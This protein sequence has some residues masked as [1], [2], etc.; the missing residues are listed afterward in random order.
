MSK[1][2]EG[3]W[4]YI[5]IFGLYQTAWAFIW[6]AYDNFFPVF[7]QAGGEH[8]NLLN[9]STAVGF[10]LGAFMTG[11]IMSLD[12]F[13]GLVFTPMFGA[14]SDF[15]KSRK[16]ITIISGLLAA[17]LVMVLP[18]FLNPINEANSGNL[19]LLI[20]P[21]LGFILT[22]F[23]MILFWSV[24]Q[25]AEAGLK[26]TLI[27]P[28]AYNRLTSF[29]MF[30]GGIGFIAA[31]FLNSM[32][33]SISSSLPFIAAGTVLLI[34]MLLYT[35][36]LKEPE[37]MSMRGP[38]DEFQK[39][40]HNPFKAFM[41]AFKLLP[42]ADIRNIVLLYLVKV[43]AIFGIMGMQTYASTWGVNWLGINEGQVPLL[44]LVYF[45]GYLGSTIPAG[46]IAD[47]IGRRNILKIGIV[48][49]AFMGL[50]LGISKNLIISGIVLFISGLGN[51]IVDVI[52]MAMVADV[53]SEKKLMGMA[54][55]TTNALG[56]LSTI[57]SVPIF[58]LILQTSRYNFLY[59]YPFMLLVPLA[60][61]L[62]LR[63]VPN[64]VGEV[65][66]E[67]VVEAEA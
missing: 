9:A 52:A 37:D 61:F 4:K 21:L 64:K 10:G 46:F 16:K 26:F 31:S 58:G 38:Q 57:I 41:I 27:P 53:V 54:M 28:E 43:C 51:G 3:L 2:K 66:E 12:N 24:N 67:E 20:L 36:L 19:S 56:K 33:Y 49:L 62:F 44:T 47:K 32:L 6:G 15:S 34:T 63:M 29:I 48:L 25:A 23:F 14:M 8:F 50:G 18:V 7:L 35:F 30:F 59:V 40:D 1:V 55:S 5:I 42:S 11:I 39:L 22:A 60:G 65:R 17:V 45:V 13:F